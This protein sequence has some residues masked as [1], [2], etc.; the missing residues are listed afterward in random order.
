MRDLCSRHEQYAER[1]KQCLKLDTIAQYIYALIDKTCAPIHVVLYI[2]AYNTHYDE[3]TP[4][5]RE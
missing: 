5:H 2:E 3:K 4:R 1:V